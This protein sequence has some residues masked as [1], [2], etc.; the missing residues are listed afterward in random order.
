MRILLTRLILS[1][2]SGPRELLGLDG[3]GLELSGGGQHLLDGLVEVGPRGR[4][5]LEAQ[6]IDARDD[7]GSQVR[8]LEALVLERLHG[9][10]DG[11]LELDDPGRA[12]FAEFY[13][14]R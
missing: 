3:I 13:G 12:L 7:E 10:R 8:A 5:A 2:P 4:P 9:G 14:P 1:G 6:G 11:F